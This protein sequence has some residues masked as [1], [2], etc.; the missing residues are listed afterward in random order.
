M[1]C[2]RIAIKL[3]ANHWYSSIPSWM[4]FKRP[5]VRFLQLRS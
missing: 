2:H 5:K 1:Y 4:G 3:G